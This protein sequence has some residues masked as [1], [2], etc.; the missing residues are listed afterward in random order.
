MATTLIGLMFLEDCLS[1]AGVAYY[2]CSSAGAREAFRRWRGQ[3][4][5]AWEWEKAQVPEGITEASEQRKR[6][7][8]KE[9]GVTGS[10]RC[11][12]AS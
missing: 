11:H 5:E 2:L 8:E 3:N 1:H 4:E 6:E 10:F 9:T 12:V 7:K